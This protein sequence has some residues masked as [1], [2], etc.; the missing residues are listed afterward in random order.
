[1]KGNN[2][3]GNIET[4]DDWETPQ[5]LFDLLDEQYNFTFDCCATKENKKTRLFS[6]DFIKQV[7]TNFRSPHILWMNPPFTKANE[8]FKHFFNIVERGVA[9]YRCDNMETKVWQDVILKNC[10]WVF[11]FKGRI[12]YEGKEF[13]SPRFPSA[14]I[15][16]GIERPV[17]L[18]YGEVLYNKK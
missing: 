2:G 8:M 7:K 13:K 1:M 15:G 16:V 10:D 12:A 6:N 3:N 17:K 9:I 4:R 11:I 14:L 5:W 18:K